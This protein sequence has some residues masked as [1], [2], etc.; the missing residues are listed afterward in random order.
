MKKGIKRVAILV[1]NL[2]NGGAERMAANMALELSA[3]YRVYLIVFDG[4]DAIYPYGGKLIDMELPPAEDENPAQLVI[5]LIKRVRRLH[6]LKRGLRIDCCISH[7]NSANVINILS[8]GGD[9]VYCVYHSMPS[10]CDGKGKAATQLHRFIAAGS[11]RYFCVSRLAALDMAKSYGITTKKLGCI[12]NFA[13][14]EKIGN[15]SREA[16]PEE[17][18]AFYRKHPSMLI[19][20]GRLTAMKA[21]DRLIRILKEMRVKDEG[22]GLTILGEGEE[23][24]NLSTLSEELELSEHVYLPGEL[25]NPFPYLRA[26]SAFILCSDYEGLPMVLIEAAA[27]G[28]P[29]AACDVASGPREILAPDSDIQSSTEVTEYARYGVLLPSLADEARRGELSDKEMLMKEAAERLLNDPELRKRYID[30]SGE[31]AERFSTG[32]QIAKWRKRIEG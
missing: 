9:K 5:K 17:A 19:T 22:V 4:K 15:W 27:C 7:M 29:V 32:R 30:S 26:A 1:Q 24:G 3:F 25:P 31:C 11:D 12:Y 13:A 16:L 21:Q 10:A 8:R 6:Y 28:L 23:R 20:M 14:L 18:A 2:H